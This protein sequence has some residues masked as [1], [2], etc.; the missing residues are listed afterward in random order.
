MRRKFLSTMITL[1]T[2]IRCRKTAVSCGF[3]LIM[4]VIEGDDV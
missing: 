2:L 4:D 3:A 1:F